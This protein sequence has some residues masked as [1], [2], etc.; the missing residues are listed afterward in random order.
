[1]I[2][3]HQ[4]RPT[5]LLDNVCCMLSI[6]EISLHVECIHFGLRTSRCQSVRFGSFFLP[7]PQCPVETCFTGTVSFRRSGFFLQQAPA[8]FRSY[9][10]FGV[11]FQ[12]STRNHQQ[13]YDL[14]PWTNDHKNL[15]AKYSI[16]KSHNVFKLEPGDQIGR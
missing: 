15:S 16:Y 10:S 7:F 9:E 12:W 11:W 8:L 1:V 3:S 2:H 6:S 13:K 14:A 5:S 4:H